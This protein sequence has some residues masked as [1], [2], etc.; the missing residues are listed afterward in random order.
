MNQSPR[1]VYSVDALSAE[2][3]KL[4]EMSYADIWIEGEVSTLTTP[5]SGHSYFTLKDQNSIL[6]CVLFKSKKYLAAALPIVGERILIRGRVSVYTARGD[7]QLICSYIEAAGE[8]QLRRQY[9]MLKKQLAA[10]GLFD[11]QHK[12]PLPT[13]PREIALI[14]SSSGAVLHDVISTLA[15]RYPFVRLRIYPANVQ[16]EQSR[17]DILEALDYVIQDA[18]DLLIIARG[19]GSLED[20]QVFNDEQIARALYACP[21]P[22]ISAIGHETDFVITDFV[23]DQRAPTP[24]GAA[25]LATPDIRESNNSLQQNRS[26][27]NTLIR[28]ALDTRQQQLD[29]ALAR[30]KHPKDRLAMQS[31]ELQQ[32]S[33]RMDAVHQLNL[34]RKQQSLAALLPRIQSLSP[35]GQLNEKRYRLPAL[36]QRLDHAIDRILSSKKATLEQHA[37]K[38]QALGPLTT[39]GRGYA[40]LQNK[41][42]EIIKHSQ[43]IKAGESFTARLHKGSLEAVVKK[44]GS[45]KSEV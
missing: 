9:E 45:L 22:C 5:A 28:Q 18:P 1:M 11:Q 38:L 4:L 29:F 7:V 2:I 36:Q 42:G 37:A 16:G 21:I 41:N 13:T 30:L 35:L 15:R 24:T 33:L 44:V 23:A 32:L 17:Q 12:L 31:S 27:L 3:K 20:L 26:A 43:Q 14:T 34:R 10:E 39:L 8:G 6:K 40:I 19:G 25:T